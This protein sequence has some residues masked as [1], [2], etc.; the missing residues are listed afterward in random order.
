MFVCIVGSEEDLYGDGGNSKPMKYWDKTRQEEAV[1]KE[2]KRKKLEEMEKT[3]TNLCLWKKVHSFIEGLP[4]QGVFYSLPDISS[5]Y[6]SSIKSLGFPISEL[7]N[8]FVSRAFL[9]FGDEFF[10]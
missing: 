2:I 5:F 10:K 4:E 7:Y 9:K 3:I 8:R 6:I 1:A